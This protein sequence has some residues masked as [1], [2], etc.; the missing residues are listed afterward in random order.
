MN[1]QR[2]SFGLALGVALTLALLPGVILAQ[3]G[4][5]SNA[6]PPKCRGKPVGY[7][8]WQGNKLKE[9]VEDSGQGGP[10][11]H[12]HVSPVKTEPTPVPPITTPEPTPMPEPTP[13]PGSPGSDDSTSSNT[14]SATVTPI[15]QIFEVEELPITGF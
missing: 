4:V 2:L 13:T 15:A 7:E 9:C 12:C 6:S 8:F 5:C 3:S 1:G 10:N 14:P 11:P